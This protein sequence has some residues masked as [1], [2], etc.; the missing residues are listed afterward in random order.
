MN[1]SP[2]EKKHINK[3]RKKDD[4]DTENKDAKKVGNIAKEIIIMKKIKR[5][6]IFLN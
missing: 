3:K 4:I 6:K 1:S 5:K 2:Y